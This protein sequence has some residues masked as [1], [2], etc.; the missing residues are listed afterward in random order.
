ML[1]GIRGSLVVLGALVALGGVG[2]G[3]LN[4]MGAMMTDAPSEGDNP[5][6]GPAIV[7]GAGVV[8]AVAGW[9]I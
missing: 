8:L 9:A 5:F 7:V 1:N 4:V 2:Y 3:V 6:I